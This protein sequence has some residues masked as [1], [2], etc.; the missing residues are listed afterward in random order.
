[1]K[2]RRTGVLLAVAVALVALSA[3]AASAQDSDA[4]FKTSK[5][6][7]LTALAPGSST[8]PLI[9]VGESL[10]GRYRFES[11]PDGVSIYPRGQ[12]RLD[13]FVNHETSRVPFP[14][15][16]LPQPVEAN[17]NDF[18]NSQVSHLVLNQHSGGI[19]SGKM[20]ITSSENFQRFCSNYLATSAEGFDRD[21]LFTNEE[22]TDFVFRTGEAWPA[23]ASDPGAEQAGVVVAYDVKNGKHKTIYGMGRHN[24]ENDVAI[25]GFDD[26]VVL[27]GDD[28][29]TSNP[30]GSQL[31]MYRAANT[32]AIWNDTGQLYGF[33]LDDVAVNDFYDIPVGS[34]TEYDGEFV[35]IS[36][37]AAQGD[38]TA[39]ESASD[40]A[41]VFQ[42]VRL[43]DIAYDKRR[44][45]SNVVYVADTG[46]GSTSVGPTGF[47]SVN[48][49]IWRL[50]F[51]DPDDP[52]QAT[53]SL[54]VE[55]EN[56]QV[57][58]APGEI[59]QPDNL[60]TTAAGSLLVQED[61]ASGQQYPFGSTDPTATT[62]RI[63]RVP[64]GSAT[65]D[66]DKAVVAKVD[67]SADESPGDRDAAAAGNLGNWESS[68]IVDASS[69]FGPG[70]FLVTIQAHTLWIEKQTIAPADDP[71]PLKRGFTN[72]REGGQLLLLKIP[73]A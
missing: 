61:P 8:T 53:L 21:I 16:A 67:Q 73:G 35:P 1:M 33:K 12:G 72:K 62:A 59:H 37:S 51:T 25:P 13:V 22:A 52:T 42:F 20:A 63:W 70:A 43:E 39:L 71:G 3:S 36:K 40:T 7:M 46:R 54:L 57:F 15:N 49:R 17:Q 10:P 68:G 14:Y 18:D 9:T 47:A 31:Y 69:V 28:T 60:E 2:R 64:L 19:L 32:D 45:M 24:H 29:F 48:G 6:S 4:G 38:Q 34:T 27:S 65:P 44:G 56:T 50:E 11:I 41:G 26:L 58:K 5:A 30:P 66:A 55:G 23:S